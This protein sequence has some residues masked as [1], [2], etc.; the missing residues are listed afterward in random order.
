[1]SITGWL[2]I[3]AASLGTLAVANIS[4]R[5]ATGRE[6]CPAIG[7]IPICHVV[8]AAYAAIVISVVLGSAPLFWA[9]LTPVFG[10]AAAGTIGE[11]VSDEPVCPR[12]SNGIPKCYLSL[13]MSLVI[14]LFGF[15][16][17]FQPAL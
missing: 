15:I 17:F 10:F 6:T 12:T 16:H 9:G 2:I 14:G 13:A 5:H 1:M 3:G 8:L 11:V 7:P 4:W